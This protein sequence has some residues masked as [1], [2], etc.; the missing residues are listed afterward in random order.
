MQ[1]NELSLIVL[2]L[3]LVICFKNI[4]TFLIVLCIIIC[5]A[6]YFFSNVYDEF[7]NKIFGKKSDDTETNNE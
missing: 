2:C 4:L 6:K 3:L 5:C 7:Y 1:M